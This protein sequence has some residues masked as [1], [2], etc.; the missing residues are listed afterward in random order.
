[1]FLSPCSINS[2]EEAQDLV[3]RHQWKHFVFGRF[4]HFWKDKLNN[5]TIE[6]N[7]SLPVSSQEKSIAKF[8]IF[9][10]QETLTDFFER[11]FLRHKHGP[12]MTAD[13]L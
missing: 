12:S 1:M 11:L 6:Q 9:L 10:Q 7:V 8:H 4:G 2:V 13:S 3:G 5:C